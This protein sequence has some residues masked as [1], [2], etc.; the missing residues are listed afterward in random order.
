MGACGEQR[1][2]WGSL[3]HNNMNGGQHCQ[4]TGT[5]DADEWQ[6]AAT[7]E[8][9]EAEESMKHAVTEAKEEATY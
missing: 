6:N 2:L 8:A 9:S 5:I 3:T 7:K 4:S 1:G